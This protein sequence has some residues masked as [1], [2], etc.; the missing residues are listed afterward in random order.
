VF[1]RRTPGQAA[2]PAEPVAKVGGKGRPTPTRR[3]AEAAARSRAKVPTSKK[4]AAKLLRQRRAEE[5]AKM[6]QGIK[7]G[8]E[9]YLPARDQG[10]V[11]RFVRDFVDSRLCM[12]EFLL[13][14]L[15]VIMVLT[16]SGNPTLQGYGNGL[17]TAIILLVIV[18]TGYLIWRIKREVRTR[19]PDETPKRLGF[20]AILRT[21]QLRF[22]RMP[23]ANLKLGQKPPAR[24]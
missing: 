18:D 14:A 1:R 20:Y 22:M 6:R 3:E 4:E 15:L 9:R 8:D 11:R 7:A 16:Y 23:K 2:A 21:M 5:N 19:F 12:A 13:P 17:W 24:Y 10:K